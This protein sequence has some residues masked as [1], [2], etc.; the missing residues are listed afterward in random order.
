M[1]IWLELHAR[2]AFS[3]PDSPDQRSIART[4]S[5]HPSFTADTVLLQAYL[6]QNIE[7][8]YK[9]LMDHALCV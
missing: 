9:T 6:M 1:K 4:H 7:K 5:F 3:L 8:A 2:N